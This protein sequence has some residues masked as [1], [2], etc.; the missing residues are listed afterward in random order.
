MKKEI[1]DLRVTYSES[2][3]TGCVFLKAVPVEGSLPECQPGQFAQLRV[4]GPGVFLRRPISIHDVEGNEIS[5]LVQ[6]VGEG[7]RWLGSLKVGDI[8]NTVLPLGRGFCFGG[9]KREERG[10]RNELSGE[11]AG[12]SSIHDSYSTLRQ[13][14]I[15]SLFSPLSSLYN[16]RPIL[17]GGGVG[18][19]PLLFLGKRLKAKGIQPT[20][21]LGA[22]TKE[23]LLRL[24]AFREVGEVLV[25]T[26]DGS[27]G[28]R[29]F[30]TQHSSLFSSLSPLH[31]YT[32]GPSP[33]MKAVARLARE[34]GWPC[35]VS[36]ENRMACGVGACLCCVE[37]TTTG[38]RCVCT[39]GP[40]FN[41]ND[42]K[43]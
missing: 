9:E 12:V 42:L 22:R 21:L 31:I 10:E 25:T 7:T 23:Q 1:L 33:M 43:W 40:V 6:V 18:V 36:L 29:G 20:F 14:D 32:C 34:K 15:I 38:N 8:V 30:V 37:D 13:E 2:V 17:I 39:D 27:M 16:K 28:E 5:F 35:E 26:E 41:I 4:D 19:A 11:G 3:G 24:D